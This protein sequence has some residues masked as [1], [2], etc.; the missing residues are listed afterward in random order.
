[1][2]IIIVN[3]VAGKGKAA[4]M[5]RRIQRDHSYKAENCRA[6]FT[7]EEGHAERI[8]RQVTEIYQD[9]LSSII[10]LGGDGT[11]HEVVNGARSYPSIPICFLPAGT[12]ND[13][14][15]GLGLRERGLP[16]FRNMIRRPR[17]HQ[18]RLG[19]YDLHGRKRNG[20]RLFL[21][22]IGFG[23]D[24]RIAGRVTKSRN[25]GNRRLF[26]SLTYPAALLASIRNSAPITVD[27]DIDGVFYPG[28]EIMMLTIAN[29]PYFGG[30][31]KIAP[32]AD[33]TKGEFE[34]LILDPISKRKL[35]VLFFSVFT[36]WHAR[37]KEVHLI[38]AKRVKITSRAA[39]PFQVDGQAGETYTCTIEKAPSKSMIA[40]D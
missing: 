30:G 22:S 40:G 18:L 13:F 8:A 9:T 23:L 25:K 38:K 2:N 26:S 7:Q 31:M 28:R 15:R 10:V 32:H 5:Y 27:L 21:N 20:T 35:A 6:F 39:V 16:L 4:K 37:I 19:C 36:G 34:L 29:H 12:G 1:M 33:L 17:I 3:P 11:L 24:G 14:A